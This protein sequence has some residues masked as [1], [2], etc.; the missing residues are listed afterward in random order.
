MGPQ[1]ICAVSPYKPHTSAT[2]QTNRHSTISL[3]PTQPPVTLCIS[4]PPS[5]TA[6][7]GE[8]NM[9]PRV[10]M[11]LAQQAFTSWGY[12]VAVARKKLAMGAEPGAQFGSCT[13]V[14]Y[15]FYDFTRVNSPL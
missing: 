11:S 1:L 8:P 15:A 12:S 10:C 2:L 14:T 7:D 4:L 3:P 6:D 9:D 13:S 5:L